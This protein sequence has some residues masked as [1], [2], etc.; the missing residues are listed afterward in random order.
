MNDKVIPLNCVTR[1]DL[2]VDRVL[3]GAK[4]QLD[5]VVILGYHKDGSEYFASTYADGGDVLWLLE[6]CKVSLL[7]VPDEYLG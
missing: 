3:D 4:D 2:P 6:R 5:G 7:K 1:L